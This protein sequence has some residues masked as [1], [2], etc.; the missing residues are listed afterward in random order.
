[1][2][3]VIETRLERRGKGVEG[4]PIRTVTQYWDEHG[5]FLA[6]RDDWAGQHKRSDQGGQ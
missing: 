6:E 2:Q 5:N 3:N 4:D 1:M